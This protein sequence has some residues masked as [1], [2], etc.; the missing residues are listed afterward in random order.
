MSIILNV[1]LII[2]YNLIIA[3]EWKEVSFLAKDLIDNLLEE[4]YE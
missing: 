1:S 4:N 2:K 3:K